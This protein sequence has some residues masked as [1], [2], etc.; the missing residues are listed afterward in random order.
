MSM[1]GIPGPAP[2]PMAPQPGPAGMPSSVLGAPSGAPQGTPAPTPP[3]NAFGA[4]GVP[5]SLIP[6]HLGGSMGMASLPPIPESLQKLVRLAKLKNAA[7][8]EEITDAQLS[9]LKNRAEE[10]LRIDLSSRTEWEE[11]A[12]KEMEAAKQK[13]KPRNYPFPDSANVCYPLIATAALQFNAR[14]YPA[15]C[16]GRNLVRASVGGEDADGAK[17][18]RASRVS[19]FMSHQIVDGMPGWEHDMDLLTYQLPIIGERFKKNYWDQALDKPQSVS[20]S[21]F[22]LIVN[23]GT[24][25]LATCPRISHRFELYPYEIEERKRDGRFLD[26]DIFGD[27]AAGGDEQHPVKLIEQHCYFDMDE[28]DLPEPWIVTFTE[29]GG[30]L[31]RLVAGF[32]P[33]DVVHDDDKIIRIP[34]D[35]YF[36]DFNFLPDPEGGFY[37]IGFGHL[38]QNLSE[39]IN[40]SFNQMLDAAHLQNAGGGFIG[41]GL[42]FQTEDEEFLFEPGKYFYVNSEAG[43]IRGNIVT[44]QHPGPSP[45]LFQ[46]LGMLM[47]SAK[48]MTS[49]Q[50]ILTGS[51]SAQNLQPTTLMALIDQGMKVFTAIYKRIYDALSHEFRIQYKLNRKYLKPEKYT[52]Y[53]GAAAT[54]EQDFADDEA[55]VTPVADPNSVTVVQKLARASF[56]MQLVQ[57]PKL[58]NMLDDEVILRRVLSAA[59]ID[60]VLSVIAKPKP[61]TPADQIQVQA[62]LAN[63]EKVKSEAEHNYA[64]A[65]RES[66]SADFASARAAQTIMAH[67]PD[68]F[69]NPI[70]QNPVNQ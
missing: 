40:T 13:R 53:I 17:A 64:L 7:T 11:Q 20:I 46:L 9:Q 62:A 43:D 22:D 52:A 57:H 38:L 70:V 50:D 68:F 4:L 15:L 29:E 39:V 21:A 1:P 67:Q 26:I 31:V 8:S 61:P 30:Q 66:A 69:Q 32:D 63:I 19:Q 34:R 23:Q 14:A 60:D 2:M 58:G 55:V 24:K 48:Q 51:V 49:I 59:E 25:S 10:G 37:G 45:V 65:S 18:A 42:D 54:V 35:D 44:M 28:D 33:L 3:Q 16:Q 36:I 56:L 5:P 47:E 12:E 41:S 6:A 27:Y